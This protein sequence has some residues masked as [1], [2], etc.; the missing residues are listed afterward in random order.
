MYWP[1]TPE[2]QSAALRE[3]ATETLRLRDA[4]KRAD[5][6]MVAFQLELVLHETRA[7]LGKRGL[8]MEPGPP[9]DGA[10]IVRL[11]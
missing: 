11:R 4:A 10:N 9:P 5:A 7:E 2:E 1:L 8:P 6:D 3:I